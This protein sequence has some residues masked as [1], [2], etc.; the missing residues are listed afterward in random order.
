MT[1]TLTPRVG[2]APAS[3]NTRRVPTIG[4][5]AAVPTIFG[6][7]VWG[8]SW[9][10][11]WGRTWLS[12]TPAVAAVPGSPAVDVTQRVGSAPS[13]NNTKRVTIA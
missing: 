10:G 5:I 3:G 2:S 11:A 1:T 12:L 7:D 9:G 13:A 6:G 8:N 4:A